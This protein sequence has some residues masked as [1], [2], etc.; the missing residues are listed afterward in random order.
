MKT[1]QTKKAEKRATDKAKGIKGMTVPMGPNDQRKVFE[2][3][4]RFGYE[5]WR[6]M[7]VRLVDVVHAAPWPSELPVPRHDY[8][9]A[10][11]VLMRL[12]RE[13][14]LQSARMDSHE[15]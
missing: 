8:T 12:V 7:I 9:P 6:E 10:E 1:N 2:L 14:K 13:G 5:D 15:Q 4:T 3:A 11:K